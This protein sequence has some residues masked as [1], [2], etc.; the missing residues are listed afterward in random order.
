MS[1]FLPVTEQ[2]SECTI[3]TN[4]TIKTVSLEVKLEDIRG[5][6]VWAEGNYRGIKIINTGD[7]YVTVTFDHWRTLEQLSESLIPYTESTFKLSYLL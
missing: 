6:V 3:V 2:R 7:E 4:K 1:K 5:V